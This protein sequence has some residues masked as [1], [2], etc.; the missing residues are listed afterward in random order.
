MVSLIAGGGAALA[1]I[2]SVLTRLPLLVVRVACERLSQSE[3]RD[4]VGRAVD[5]PRV[6]IEQCAYGL[7]KLQRAANTFRWFLDDGHVFLLF[8]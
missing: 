1:S 8:R 2:D 4:V 3:I 6:V 5:E 7:F